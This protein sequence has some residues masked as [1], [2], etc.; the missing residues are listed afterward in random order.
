VLLIFE[1]NR[2]QVAQL[3]QRDRATGCDSFGQK[4]KT[5]TTKQYFTDIIGLF[6]P[7]RHNQSATLSKSVKEMQHNSCYAAQDHSRTW[8]SLPIEI[9]SLYAISY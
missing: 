1:L 6:Q 2:E 4:L 8:R 7:L 3:S 9:G 5:G